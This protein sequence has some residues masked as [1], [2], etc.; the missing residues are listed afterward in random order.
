M[1]KA[2]ESAASDR[3]QA[4]VS[5]VD[6]S[7]PANSRGPNVGNAV[8]AGGIQDT[9]EKQEAFRK[10]MLDVLQKSE[11]LQALGKKRDELQARLDAITK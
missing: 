6:S 11:E 2:R 7:G 5:S 10:N 4:A 9:A 1:L 8:S 3:M